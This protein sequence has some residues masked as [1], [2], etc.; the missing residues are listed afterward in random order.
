M[1]YSCIFQQFIIVKMA[2]DY[3]PL[4]VPNR[5][6]SVGV[7]SELASISTSNDIYSHQECAHN[8]S[9]VV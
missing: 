1:Q 6:N 4:T 3:L 2:S 7:S 8:F 5:H 9:E